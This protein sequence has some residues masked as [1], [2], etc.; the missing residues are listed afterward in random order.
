MASPTGRRT[1]FISVTRE[2]RNGARFGAGRLPRRRA[3][4]DEHAVIEVA[5]VGKSRRHLPQAWPARPGHV[6]FPGLRGCRASGR[7]AGPLASDPWLPLTDGG[8]G[9]HDWPGY[10]R[11]P[12]GSFASRQA[13]V[14]CGGIEATAVPGGACRHGV[15]GGE[16]RFAVGTGPRSSAAGSSGPAGIPARGCASSGAGGMMARRPTWPPRRLPGFE[17]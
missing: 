8:G 15:L 10:P 14:R 1:P 11:P 16:A 4:C 12:G 5:R 7:Q 2:R 13:R 3:A 17:R 6:R 9:Q